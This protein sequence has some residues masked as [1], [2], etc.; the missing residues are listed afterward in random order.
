MFCKLGSVQQ[1]F[2]SGRAKHKGNRVRGTEELGTVRSDGA[3]KAKV[4]GRIPV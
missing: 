4:T 3:G 1:F 2:L